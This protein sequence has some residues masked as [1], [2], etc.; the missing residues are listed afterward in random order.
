MR[1]CGGFLLLGLVI[2]DSLVLI[3]VYNDKK[4]RKLGLDT[5]HVCNPMAYTM[6]TYGMWEIW[7]YAALGISLRG[8]TKRWS[9]LLTR[10][11]RPT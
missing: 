11:L 4:K 5:N 3:I 7:S 2:V 8:L 9:R 6:V 1:G 10:G